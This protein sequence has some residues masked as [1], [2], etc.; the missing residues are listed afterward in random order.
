MGAIQKVT[1]NKEE[2]TE[3]LPCVDT[4]KEEFKWLTTKFVLDWRYR[5]GQEGSKNEERHWQRRARLVAREYRSEGNRDDVF[6]PATSPSLTRLIPILSLQRKWSLRSLDIKDAFLLVKQKEACLCKVPKEAED[7]VFENPESQRSQQCWKLGRV[8][9]GQRDA[10][11]L[12]ADFFAEMLQEEG[13]T[14]SKAAP[15]VRAAIWTGS[16]SVRTQERRRALR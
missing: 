1:V 11:L 10:A 9:P 16:S 3:E 4:E 13:W 7:V 6:A 12:W 2:E 15:A 8:L 14:R 5:E